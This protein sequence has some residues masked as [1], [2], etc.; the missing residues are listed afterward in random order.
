MG[1]G[2]L[3][4]LNFGV[5]WAGVK[6]PPQRYSYYALG[7]RG[8]LRKDSNKGGL[9]RIYDTASGPW[10]VVNKP[11]SGRDRHRAAVMVM[12]SVPEAALKA[13]TG[14]GSHRDEHEKHLA[15]QRAFQARRAEENLRR[16]NR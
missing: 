1:F 4:E 14:V 9:A 6:R 7:S 16:R 13:Q 2:P 3:S 8:A 15:A 11:T 12:R 5:P 10:R